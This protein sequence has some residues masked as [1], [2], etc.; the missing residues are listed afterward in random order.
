MFLAPT[1]L[2]FFLW[3]SFSFRF[4]AAEITSAV[5]YLHDL[6]IV[7]RDLK[8][9]NILLN[10]HGQCVCT[11][12]YMNVHWA[13]GSKFPVSPPTFLT[14]NKNTGGKNFFHR[15]L[16]TPVE[17]MSYVMHVTYGKEEIHVMPTNLPRQLG[18][19][20]ELEQASLRTEL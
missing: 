19:S 2:C 18:I 14:R 10:R 15:W 8:P 17:K 11:C 9:E 4:Y 13:A 12:M 20:T 6:N 16:K 1:D 5:G 7:Y 3:L